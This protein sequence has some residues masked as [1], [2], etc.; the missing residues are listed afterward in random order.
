VNGFADKAIILDTGSTDG[1]QEWL[2]NKCPLPVAL[3]QEPFINFEASR[4]RLMELAQNA[5]D[6]L[7]LLDDDMALRFVDGG[8]PVLTKGVLKASVGNY[9]LP[10]SGA[11][12]YWHPRLVKGSYLWKYVGVTHEYL[13]PQGE[14]RALLGVEVDHFYVHTPEKFTRDLRLLTAD[15]ARDPADVRTVFYIANTLRDMGQLV[16]AIHFY[17][18]RVKMGGWDQE[19]YESMYEAARLA[20][21]SAAMEKA[22]KFRS[23]R[24]EPAAWLSKYYLRASLNSRL[25]EEEKKF[26]LGLSQRWENIRKEIPLSTDT[27]FVITAAYGPISS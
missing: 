3:Y 17:E 5:A 21:D 16:P 27:I 13:E 11:L 23:S 18:M 15:L 19:I 7:L 12:L 2:K 14:Q 6:W 9:L 22:F 1:T 10:H 25:T 4:N 24:A 26:Y 20:E 8:S